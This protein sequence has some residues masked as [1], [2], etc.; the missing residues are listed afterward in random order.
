LSVA[1][2]PP[3]AEQALAHPTWVDEPAPLYAHDPNA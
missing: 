3:E 2:D 1:C